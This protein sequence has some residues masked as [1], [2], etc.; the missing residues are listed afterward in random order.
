MAFLKYAKAVVQKVNINGEQWYKVASKSDTFN[1][2]TSRVAIQNYSPD[3]YLLTH[4]TIICSVD[5]EEPPNVKVGEVIE[6]SRK[7]NRKYADYWITPETLAGI[8]S[9]YDAW[10]RKLLLATY[11]TFIGAEN[12]LEHVQV[13]ELSKGKI[14]DAVARDLGDFIY[15]DILVATDRK[16][17]AL[18]KDIESRKMAAMSMGCSIQYSQCTKCGNVAVDETELCNCIK[19]EKG[20]TFIRPDGKK[21]VIAEL[22]GN[23]DD[24]D[25]VQFIEASWVAN[26][27]FKGAVT[28]NILNMGSTTIVDSDTYEEKIK[29]AYAMPSQDI[30]WTSFF[31]KT[32]RAEITRAMKKAFDFEEGE[33][34]GEGGALPEELGLLDDVKNQIKDKVKQQIINDLRD[35]LGEK[36]VKPRIVPEQEE[37]LNENMIQSS[38]KAYASFARRYAS[39]L[40]ARTKTAFVAYTLLGKGSLPKHKHRFA[41]KDIIAALYLHDCHAGTELQKPLYKA[42]YTVGGTSGYKTA[43]EFV[44]ACTKAMG[45]QLSRAEL[46][47]L[48]KRAQTLN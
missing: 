4:S 40:G 45:R 9:N 37:H 47:E 24:P 26:P 42:L 16:H 14:I 6:G 21:G 2:R 1:D 35:E 32:A 28:H 39:K 31:Q 33:G 27:A 3:K 5:T 25:S 18:I 20:N 41:N 15:V 43:S 29:S 12:Y 30:D 11:K 38:K 22:C 10:E 44:K 8:N 46:T 34:G 36:K 7:I 17:T 48:I 23:K 13:P 19:Y